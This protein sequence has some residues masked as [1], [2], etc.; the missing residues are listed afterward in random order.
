VNTSLR[1]NNDL[2][3]RAKAEAV[4]RGITLTA[5]IEQGLWLNLES[6]QTTRVINLPTFGGTGFSLSNTEVNS[7]NGDERILEQL[8]VQRPA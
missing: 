7:L 3:R 4:K 8:K 5:F 6:N 1:I 2:Y